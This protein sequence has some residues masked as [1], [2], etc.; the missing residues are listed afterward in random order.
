MDENKEKILDTDNEIRISHRNILWIIYR[1]LA[2][3][4]NLNILKRDDEDNTLRR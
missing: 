3:E 2:E 4:M 1:A